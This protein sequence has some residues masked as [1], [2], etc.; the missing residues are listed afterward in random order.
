MNCETKQKCK[1]GDET[2][3]NNLCAHG[4]ADGICCICEECRKEFEESE[5]ESEDED[6]DKD[7]DKKEE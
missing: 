5:G 2:H 7:E 1:C 6:E 3:I 4:I